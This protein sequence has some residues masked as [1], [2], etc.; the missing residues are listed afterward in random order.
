MLYCGFETYTKLASNN[1]RFLMEL[2]YKTFERH[3]ETSGDLSSQVRAEI[4]TEAAILIGEKN[5]AQL[6][7]VEKD[8]PR[9][10]RLL[11]GLGR[12]FECLAKDK[13]LGTPEVNQFFIQGGD[14]DDEVDKLLSVA[15]KNLAILRSPGNKLD[16]AQTKAYDYF[17]HPI[18][19]PFF[20]FSYRRKR[21]MPLLLSELK[22]LSEQPS[23]FV[24]KVLHRYKNSESNDGVPQLC[25]EL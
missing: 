14:C 8:G 21:K 17:I 12:V 19:A 7:C 9:I 2:I 6:E 24:D 20:V 22:G 11:C 3:I 4:Q 23:K 1:I 5:L 10:V 25:F 13:D 18:F 15:V 16:G